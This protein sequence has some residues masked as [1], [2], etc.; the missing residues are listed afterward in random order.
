MTNGDVLF[1]LL[2]S[3]A[4]AIVI[5]M[6]IFSYEVTHWADRGQLCLHWNNQSACLVVVRPPGETK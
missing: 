2:I 4:S 1:V 5:P 3:I 6:L